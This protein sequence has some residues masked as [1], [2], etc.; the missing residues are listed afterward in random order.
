MGL[1]P[2]AVFNEFAIE[3]LL[4]SGGMGTV[5]L[6][7]HPRLRRRVALKVLTDTFTL[8][9]KA[10]AAFDR[11]ANLAAGLDHP[12]IVPVYDR[13]AAD[14]PD[15]WLAMR[16]IDGGDAAALLDDHP[17][18]LT[19]ERSVRLLADA[20]RALDYA[21]GRGVLHRDVK[22]ANLLIETDH[23]RNERAVLTD[24]GIARTLDDTVTMSGIAASFAYAAPERFTDSP[25][26]HR[27]DIY[28][29]GCT[30]YQ[31][32]TG[33]PPFPRKDQAAV[34][35]AHL[36]A[37]P[38][39]PRALR[40]DLPAELDVIIATA[41]AKS[42]GDRYPN[43]TALAEAATRCLIPAEATV[44]WGPP[45]ANPARVVPTPP[46]GTSMSQPPLTEST[47]PAAAPIPRSSIADHPFADPLSS[48]PAVAATPPHPAH[49]PFA[50][51]EPSAPATAT[52]PPH[53]AD[54]PF[55]DQLPSAPA[56][57]ATPPHLADTPTPHP[58]IG[59]HSPSVATPHSAS[60]DRSVESPAASSVS[61]IATEPNV[62][63]SSRGRRL[64]L[65]AGAGV[66]VAAIGVAGVLYTT[67]DTANTPTTPTS[68]VV[69]QQVTTTVTPSPTTTQPPT[70]PPA[71]T[72]L[73]TADAP[74]EPA[75]PTAPAV[76]EHTYTP[77]VPQVVPRSKSY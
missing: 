31:L 48:A 13:N 50:D 46:V 15:L 35:G 67:R 71:A 9:S 61:R 19:P 14:D 25:A 5:Y 20:A 60:V 57:A 4:G 63:R 65:A 62:E 2:G 16:Y 55:A 43:C 26:D 47:P 17:D 28:S 38:P 39:A 23:K 12:N 44:R 3:R 70:T 69:P 29:L 68:S 33:R 37:P 74:T 40:P 22:P 18:G 66:L 53:P 7:R 58:V 77:A 1:Q 21:H 73:A 8:D 6:A 59:E 10:R 54:T 34:I 11:E 72:T 27:A 76:Q 42:P 49:H 56:V 41:L 51:P 64:A 45:A 24:F 30:L 32:L 52:A 75:Q 36:T